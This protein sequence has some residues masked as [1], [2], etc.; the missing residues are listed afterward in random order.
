MIKE[1][2]LTIWGRE[3]SLP[4]IYECYDCE[5]ITEEQQKAAESF[6]AHPERIDSVKHKVEDY[7]KEKVLDDSENENKDNIFSYVKP[8]R[9]LVKHDQ[10]SP[11]TAL[12]CKYRYDQ[13]H[14]LAVV[15]NTDGSTVVGSQDIII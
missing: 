11:R 14:G 10:I 7:C 4:I 12:M 9:L 15:F 2:N 5:T 8:E 1:I 6:A 3:F 13:E